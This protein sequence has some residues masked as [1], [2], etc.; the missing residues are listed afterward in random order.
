MESFSSSAGRRRGTRRL[1]GLVAAAD[2]LH[3]RLA[4]EAY[5]A[6]RRNPADFNQ[7][8]RDHLVTILPDI[9]A[10]KQALGLFQLSLD[11]PR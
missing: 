2:V 5:Q 9:E 3:N 10:A 6:V 11:S 4:P 8:L 1:D 7:A